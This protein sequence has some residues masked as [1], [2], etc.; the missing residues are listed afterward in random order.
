MPG[1]VRIARHGVGT[2]G[3]AA[4]VLEVLSTSA[5]SFSKLDNLCLPAADVGGGGGG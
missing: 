5:M 4:A 3:A 2:A 1:E